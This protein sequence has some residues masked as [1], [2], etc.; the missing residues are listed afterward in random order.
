MA[1]FWA[2]AKAFGLAVWDRAKRTNPFVLVAIIMGLYLVLPPLSGEY[3]L[4]NQIKTYRRLTHNRREHARLTRE[5][6]ETKK[7][8]EELRY[9]KDMLEKYAREK[10]LMKSENED[11]YL[12]K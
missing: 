9:H 8:L 4:W 6:E 11:L 7:E 1:E 10:F 12:L 5:I 3:S 2:K